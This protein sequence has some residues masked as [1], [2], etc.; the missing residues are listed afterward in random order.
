MAVSVNQLFKQ[1]KLK[2]EGPIKWGDLIQAKGNGVYIISLSSDP[3]SI[4]SPKVKFEIN[5][6]VFTFWQRQAPDLKINDKLV[7]SIDQIRI[8]LKRHWKPNEHILYI[9]EA[10][11]KTNPIQKRVHQY[12]QHRVGQKG[13]HT[14]GYWLKLLL[15]LEQVYIY[16]AHCDNPRDTEFKMLIHFVE[17][18]TGKSLYDIKDVAMYLP[19]ANLKADIIK[20]H[21]ISNAMKK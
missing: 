11:S 13:P 15:C 12:Y 16:Y 17:H 18:S 3:N 1:V 2:G 10:T 8:Y 9:G 4:K 6:E 20:S 19:F 21:G 5:K 7:S 14:G